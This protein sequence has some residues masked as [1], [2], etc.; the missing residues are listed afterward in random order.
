[1]KTLIDQKNRSV[2]FSV[3]TNVYPKDIVYKACYV[4]IDRMYIFLDVS[5]KKDIIFVTL[6]GKESLLKKNIEK[7]EGEFMNEL[8]N[9]LVRENISKR[10]QKVLEQ[11]VGGAMG[12]A[13]GIQQTVVS[14]EK[15]EGEWDLKD[16]ADI[17]A[18]IQ[19]L[20]AELE[21]VDIGDDEPGIGVVD[22][23]IAVLSD[24]TAKKSVS[25]KTARSKAAKK[26]ENKRHAKKK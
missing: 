4:F 13:L 26:S 20:R 9:S 12:A 22:M 19:A 21:M 15:R 11:I 2:T 7:L 23:E 18:A 14:P 16:D 6:K 17:E 5:P 25:P 3:N 24:E 1:M 8:L 10:N